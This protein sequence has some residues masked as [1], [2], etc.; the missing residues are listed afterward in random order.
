MPKKN[1]KFPKKPQ[2]TYKVLRVDQSKSITRVLVGLAI[3]TMRRSRKGRRIGNCRFILIL[4][5][6]CLERRDGVEKAEI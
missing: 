6:I 5:E 2:K 1:S 3:I 4:F